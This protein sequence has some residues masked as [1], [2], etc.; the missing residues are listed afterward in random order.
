MSV[1]VVLAVILAVALCSLSYPAIEDARTT[2]AEHHADGELA[3]VENA[4]IDLSEENAVSMAHPGAR[5]A[6][7]L[8]LPA[9]SASG[10]GIAFIAIGGLP[11][12]EHGTDASGDVLAYRVGGEIHVRHVPFDLRVARRSE[13]KDGHGRILE[14]DRIPLVVRSTGETEI[15][16]SLVERRGKR[17]VLVS[18]TDELPSSAA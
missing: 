4:L 15:V 14:S 3:T 12:S 5:R 16:L 9:E 1:R 17:L 13:Q 2:R 6:I 7:T 18:R 11:G 10:V 8:S